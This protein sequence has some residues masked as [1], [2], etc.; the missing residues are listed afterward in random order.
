MAYDR[1]D[2][3]Y[4]TEEEPLP[5]GHAGTH[6]GMFLAWQLIMDC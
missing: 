4:S 2:F 5:K 1:A 6:I 3:D